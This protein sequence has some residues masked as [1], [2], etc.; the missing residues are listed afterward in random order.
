MKY[1]ALPKI[2]TLSFGLSVTAFLPQAAKSQNVT[3]DSSTDIDGFNQV[4]SPSSANPDIAS[5]SFTYSSGAG[6]GG[7]GGLVFAASPVDTTAIYTGSSFDLTGG[8]TVTLSIDFLTGTS[9]FSG[10]N[11]AVVMLGLTGGTGQGFY[12]YNN[13]TAGDDFIGGRLR[14]VSSGSLNGLQSQTK[15]LTGSAASSPSDGSIASLTFTSDEWYQ[16]TLSLS[17]TATAN[18]FSYSMSLADIGSDGTSAPSALGSTVVGTFSNSSLYNDSTLYAAFRGVPGVG[19]AP[20]AFDNFDVTV[21]PVPEPASMTLAALGG[22]GL[23][24]FKRKQK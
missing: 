17:Q 24:L 3:F 18:T 21:T 23:L 12:S 6:T 11:N 5:T 16:M 1:N 4:Q 13:A 10:A 19:G 14:H 22:L 2:L 7:S 15:T 8:A 20:T 9:P